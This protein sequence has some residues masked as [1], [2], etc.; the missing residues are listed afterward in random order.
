MDITKLLL[1]GG[2]SAGVILI[3]YIGM[4]SWIKVIEMHL[5]GQL[6]RFDN[7]V[8]RFDTF[9]NSVQTD[10]RDTLLNQKEMR[11]MHKVMIEEL[12]A[13]TN[14]ANERHKEDMEM[15]RRMCLHQERLFTQHNE[16]TQ[17]LRS[18]HGAR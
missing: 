14:N 11:D 4:K 9:A 7:L 13:H 18:M 12:K 16:I 8:N 5:N 6:M 2:I 3:L 15:M 17:I 10:H 1:E